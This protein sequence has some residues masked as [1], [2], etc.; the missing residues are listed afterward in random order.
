MV[1]TVTVNFD[2]N[3][4]NYGS[5]LG[6]LYARRAK[7]PLQVFS[8]NF[9]DERIE[10]PGEDR[11]GIHYEA[12]ESMSFKGIPNFPK[13]KDIAIKQTC[14]LKL[15]KDKMMKKQIQ[16]E[17]L[18]EREEILSDEDA[19]RQDLMVLECGAVFDKDKIWLCY[20]K[21]NESALVK[22][23]CE[24]SITYVL[25]IK[26][27]SRIMCIHAVNDN[28]IVLGMLSHLIYCFNTRSR[29]ELWNIRVNDT[30]LSLCSHTDESFIRIYAALA[31]GTI[32]VIEGMDEATP[33]ILYI[34]IGS[35]PV[36]CLHI[37]EEKLWCGCGNKVVILNARCL[38][39]IDQFQTTSSSL[40]HVMSLRPSQNGVWVT[41]KGSN[42]L[43]L[44]DP[45][46]FTCILLF[47]IKKNKVSKPSK[48]EETQFNSC[49]VT[50]ILSVQ[51]TVWVG[52]ADGYMNIYNV[53]SKIPQNNS[54]NC[55]PQTSLASNEVS[56]LFLMDHR[57]ETCNRE[58]C[59]SGCFTA[60]SPSVT[61][62]ASSSRR[63]TAI[64]T[65]STSS[66]P[67]HEELDLKY[68]SVIPDKNDLDSLLSP[69]NEDV[70]CSS[71][72]T[73]TSSMNASACSTETVK[74][75]G[76]AS[77][78]LSSKGISQS[79]EDLIESSLNSN[80]R[81]TSSKSL[82]NLS[83]IS[84]ILKKCTEIW[85]SKLMKRK[86]SSDKSAK[87][88]SSELKDSE[89]RKPPN[90]PLL[91]RQMSLDERRSF[92]A[93]R[94]SVQL[95][96][97]ENFDS[98]A[99]SHTEDLKM[100]EK[101]NNSVDRI[102]NY[103]NIY[104]QQK[105]LSNILTGHRTL[106]CENNLKNGVEQMPLI[107]SMWRISINGKTLENN[108]K[109]S[110]SLFNIKSVYEN[111]SRRLRS[112]SSH[113]ASAEN[114]NSCPES[115]NGSVSFGSL[116]FDD[117][118]VTY[119]T[120]DDKRKCNGQM[121]QNGHTEVDIDHHYPEMQNGY[122]DFV[123]TSYESLTPRVIKSL[124]GDAN[125]NGHIPNEK[126]SE[127]LLSYHNIT[128]LS[129]D[130]KS[131]VDDVTPNSSIDSSLP[132]W[133]SLEDSLSP[134]NN[135]NSSTEEIQK[136]SAASLCRPIGEWPNF[137][138]PGQ[139]FPSE[140]ISDTASSISFSSCEL[141]YN[142]ELVIE[143]KIKVSDKPIKCILETSRGSETI[144]I[145]CSGYYGEDEGILKWRKSGDLWTNEPVV[146]VCP[147]TNKIKP[148]Q[149]T[150]SRLP[151]SQ[152]QKVGNASNSGRKSSSSSPSLSSNT[153]VHKVQSIF[154]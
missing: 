152:D 135:N 99:M 4:D 105:G 153:V 82:Y 61:T 68:Q 50:S 154:S 42:I 26:F 81:V 133:S 140:G 52:T 57:G 115:S 11:Y 84:N 100:C 107:K 109:N 33:E 41:I 63:N 119:N 46:T 150:R 104:M 131:L 14:Y 17:I 27:G 18:K 137:K 92:L 122:E 83:S 43:E 20:G 113:T 15:L 121:K 66:E 16:R 141:P 139:S 80:I 123:E 1:F 97:A 87:K 130:N 25:N 98:S 35:S 110:K 132:G 22:V 62:S 146:E 37:I 125:Q 31:D 53:R 76:C 102:E 74:E 79:E 24:E 93:K 69:L 7:G 89:S 56:L 28:I 23:N 94:R 45:L 77:M 21:Q 134:F 39:T 149:F 51:N 111:D 71:A 32:A 78:Y 13:R 114:V 38:D 47:D 86:K 145:S 103:K 91:I 138:A 65:N 36:T 116:D 30:V 147:Y 12:I 58:R 85:K 106:N 34:L 129:S 55:T 118:F 40:D 19:Q 60:P 128:S 54:E 120:D 2:R 96:E 95:L 73:T 144:I 49:R 59:D 5:N 48:D 148:S 10:P 44:W 142:V 124:C 151:Q 101:N 6:L 3:S 9:E 90:R 8:G 70:S 127:K 72:S 64:K 126:S 88:A 143:E 75:N 117:V 136:L 108:L 112:K 29:E 67:T